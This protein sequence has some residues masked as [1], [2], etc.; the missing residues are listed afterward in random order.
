MRPLQT[1]LS[2]YSQFNFERPPVG[3][4]YFF[5]K[6][7][8]IEKLDKQLGLCEMVKEAQQRGKPFYFTSEEENCIGKVFLG[9]TGDTQHRSDGGLLGVK[10]QL[11]QQGRANLRLRSFIPSL[12][13]GSVNYVVFSPIDKLEFE[14]DLLVFVATPSQAEILLRGMTY[15]TGEMYESRATVVGY[16]SSLFVYPYL[17]GKVNYTITGLSYGMEGREVFPEGL[18]LISI[19]YQWIPT[20]TQNLKEMKWVPPGYTFH[21]RDKFIEFD[22]K[23]TKEIAEESQNP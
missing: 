22:E 17:S 14:P 18:V 6:P 7:E 1:D 15:S 8:G 5:H 23:I 16:C 12:E 4:N 19:P 13:K 9:M 21:N 11:F 3:V 10:L 2:V 20:I